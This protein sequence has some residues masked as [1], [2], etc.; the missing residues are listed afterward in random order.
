MGGAYFSNDNRP[1]GLYL[2]GGRCSNIEKCNRIGKYQLVNDLWMQ[3]AFMRLSIY[4]KIC[5]DHHYRPTC[6]SQSGHSNDIE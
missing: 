3:L 2:R 4:E 6:I 1:M 5:N